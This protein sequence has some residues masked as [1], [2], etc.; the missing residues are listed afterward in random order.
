[1]NETLN[2]AKELIVKK[3]ITPEDA[4][5]QDFMIQ[6]LEKLGFEIENMPHGKVKNFM[7]KKV[8]AAHL[9]FLLGILMLFLPDL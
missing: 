3:S 5:C 2:T 9:L 8:Q 1:M 4:G 6:R 7:Q